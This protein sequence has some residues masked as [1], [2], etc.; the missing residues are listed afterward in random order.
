M[1][2]TAPPEFTLD[3][4][5]SRKKNSMYF[6]TYNRNFFNT[7]LPASVCWERDFYLKGGDARDENS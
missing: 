3:S 2:I 1:K 4:A 7:P 6:I 5:K